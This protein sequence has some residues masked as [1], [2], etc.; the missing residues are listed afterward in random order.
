V[1]DDSVVPS[2]LGV[3]PQITILRLATRLAYH[4]L[5][6]AAPDDE[7]EPVSIAEP[8]ISRA[9]LHGPEVAARV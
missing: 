2:S 4:L 7:P 9:A 8:P 6:E 5:G 1:A 3:N